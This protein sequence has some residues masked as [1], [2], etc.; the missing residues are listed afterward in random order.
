MKSI[1][2]FEPIQ[3]PGDVYVLPAYCPIPGLGVLPMHSLLI[4]GAEPTL[5]DT[6]PPAT[7]DVLIERL[8]ALVDLEDLRWVWITHADPDHVGAL[9]AV[10]ERAP[11]ARVVTTFM[12]LGKLG[13]SGLVP[14]ERAYLINPGQRLDIGDREL[15]ALR[16]PIYDAPETLAAFDSRTRALFAADAFG[17]LLE[18]PAEAAAD[19]APA[20]LRRGMLTW[21]GV[22]APWL[23]H[24]PQGALA[25]ALNDVRRLEPSAIFSAH[26]PP[27]QGASAAL[28]DV[29]LEASGAPPF[30]GPDQRALEA[31][32][33]PDAEV[34]AAAGA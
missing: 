16:P 1:T 8:S 34:T 22:D 17:A 27:A 6:G 14:P 3:Q 13:L 4:R 19:I 25:A 30:V 5:I 24:L 23:E 26:L 33:R 32:A 15:V 12:G 2:A 9:A 28:M 11:A 7:S 20:V 10:L 21:A 29:L 18:A 31:L